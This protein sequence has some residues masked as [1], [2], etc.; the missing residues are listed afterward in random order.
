MM[1]PAA[2]AKAMRSRRNAFV[3]EIRALSAGSWGNVHTVRS[4]R[5][6]VGGEAGPGARPMHPDSARSLRTQFKA[7]G[8]PSS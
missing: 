1:M 8:V 5:V 6:V 2:S 7:G 3:G 4:Q